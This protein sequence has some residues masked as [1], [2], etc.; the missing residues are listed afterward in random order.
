MK[1]KLAIIGTGVAGM[2]A[3]Y[4][5]KDEYEIS[6]YEKNSYIGGHTN[7]VYVE[8]DGKE[9]SIDTGFMVFNE[10]TYPNLIN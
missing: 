7:T 10:V 5:L 8:E 1:K 6:V 3:A 9:L 4:F 2:S